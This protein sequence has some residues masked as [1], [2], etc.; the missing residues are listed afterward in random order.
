QIDIPMTI[1]VGDRNIPAN[2]LLDSGCTGCCIDEQFVK[3]LNLTTISLEKEIRVYNADASH[4]KG[5]TV[6]KRVL[7]SITI[8][9]HTSKQSLLVTDIG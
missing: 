4:N 6:K 1:E 9:N 8:R 3:K 5:G 7:L 2:A